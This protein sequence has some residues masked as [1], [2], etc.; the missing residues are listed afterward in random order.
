[1]VLVRQDLDQRAYSLTLT[2]AEADNSFVHYERIFR[3][4]KFIEQDYQG[5]VGRFDEPTG[6]GMRRRERRSAGSVVEIISKQSPLQVGAFVA[7]HWF[8][9]LLF[10][11][12]VKG[13]LIGTVRGNYNS[14]E[15]FVDLVES[16][17]LELTEEFPQYELESLR[18]IWIWFMAM[19]Q[20]QQMRFVE[21]VKR[22]GSALQYLTNI[23]FRRNR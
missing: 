16:K 3:M 18:E 11:V 9:L 22:Y 6:L 20:D 7:E 1:M 2:F 8:E 5:L 17:V 14:F 21:R 12:G 15:N 10:V 4:L 19:S 23:R 13:D